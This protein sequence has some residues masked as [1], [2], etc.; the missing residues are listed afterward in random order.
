MST[1]KRRLSS[2]LAALFLIGLALWMQSDV[3]AAATLT[4]Q[5]KIQLS[6][7]FASALDLVTVSAPLAYAKQTNLASGVGLDQADQIFSDT[8]T[9]APS[10]AE[11]LDVRGGALLQPDGTPFNIVKLKVLMVCA[12][13]T[14]TNN[15]VLGGDANSVPFLDTAATTTTIKPNGCRVFSES[16]LAGIAV[17]AGTGDVVQVANS[18]AGTS[19]DYD[20]VIIGTSS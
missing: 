2:G 5:L 6:G 7:Q 12:K 15:V 13:S 3:R 9:L 19:V 14:N 16:A 17:T 11:D 1:I 8:R 20:I 4:T 10:T 18:A